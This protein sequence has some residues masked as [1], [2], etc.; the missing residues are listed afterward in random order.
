MGRVAADFPHPKL[1]HHYFKAWAADGT[2]NRMHNHVPAGTGR[3]RP[4]ICPRRDIVD[5]IRHL[6]PDRPP[7]GND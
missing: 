5:A 2:L 7:G 4:I 6:D 1:V 3:G